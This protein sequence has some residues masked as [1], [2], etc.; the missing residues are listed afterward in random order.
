[1]TAATAADLK[2]WADAA[3]AANVETWSGDGAAWVQFSKPVNKLSGDWSHWE[4]GP[5]NNPVSEDGLIKAPY[6]TQFMAEPFYIA[7]PAITTAAAGRTFLAI[8]HI[9]HHRREWDMMNKL[10]ARN[11]YNGTLLWERPLPPGYLVHRSA[12]IATRDAFHMIEGNRCLLLDP[13]TGRENGEIRISGVNGHWKWMVIKDDVLYVLAGKPD[14]KVQSMKGDRSFGGWSWGDLSQGYYTKPRVAWGFGNTLAAYDLKKKELLWKHDEEKPIDSR[15]LSMGEDRIS[16][17]CPTQHLRCLNLKSGEIL[18]TNDDE[19][20]LGLIE[21]PGKG[22]TST[23]GFRTA[24]LA[25]HTPDAI[26]IQ[27]QTRMNVVAISTADGYQLWTKKKVTNNPNAI[28]VDGKVILG[29]GP[30][31]SHVAVDPVSG[32]VLEDLGFVKRACTRLTAS[33]D[34]FFVRGEGTLRYDRAKKK[35]LIDGAARPACNDGALPANGLLYVGPWQCDCNLSLIGRI[36]KCSAGDFQFQDAVSA[37]ARLETGAGD[38]ASVAPLTVNE[39][40]WPTFRGDNDRSSSTSVAAATKIASPWMFRPP[41]GAVPT[42]SVA[43][44]DLVFSAGEDGLVR[45]LDATNGQLRWQYATP[46]PIKAAPS[47]ADSRLYFGSGDGYAYCLEATTG[48][49]LWRFRAGPAE[50]HILVY[51]NLSST[52]PVNSGVLVQDGVAY[53][54]AGIIDYDGTYVYALDAKTGALKWKNDS[55][56]HLSAELR[57]GVSVQGNLAIAGDQLLLA[58][59]NQVSPARFDLATGKCLTTKVAQ[60]QPV[61]NNGQFAGALFGKHPVIGGRTLYSAPENVSTKGSFQIFHDSRAA[62]LNYGGIP[63]AWSDDNLLMV[64]YQNGQLTCVDAAKVT[65]RIAKGFDIPPNRRYRFSVADVLKDE[66]AVR[67][68]ADL[69][70]T[71]KLEFVSIAACPNAVVA[72]VQYQMKFRAQ[73]QWYAVAFNAKTGKPFWK[74]ELF[75]TPLPGGLLIDRNG[76]SVVTMIDGTVVSLGEAAKS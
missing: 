8:G 69:G 31:G 50:R 30:R 74:Q 14:P 18:W 48:R 59:G 54:A 25:V 24:C 67:W 28:Y 56:G 64:N 12:F 71:N 26:I 44:G 49:L 29:V 16:L 46:S 36:G 40:D 15:A 62:T 47:I 51:G 66:Q 39:S 2:T 70:E 27:G 23:P 55:T 57:K 1:M 17:Y 38:L 42:A 75:G 76:R 33:S 53:F 65:E 22:L 34:S 72:V 52:W 11:G 73:P 60:G 6:M 32:E 43:A 4:H 5:D 37:E 9:T 35:I 10:I 58:G 45:A 19:K 68:Q 3:G 63:P 13:E 21:E 20:T 7:M 61:S 41:A